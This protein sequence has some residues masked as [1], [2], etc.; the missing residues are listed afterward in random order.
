[1]RCQNLGHLALECAM[2]EK[3]CAICVTNSH[4]TL[5]CYS[6]GRGRLKKEM[7]A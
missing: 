4:N 5:D 3:W 2:N 1:M 6:N 7:P